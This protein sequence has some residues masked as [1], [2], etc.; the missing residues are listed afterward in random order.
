M[1][2]AGLVW[3]GGYGVQ[4]KVADGAMVERS[5]EQV[6]GMGMMGLGGIGGDHRRHAV[7][8]RRDRGRRATAARDGR[9]V[10]GDLAGA[11]TAAA[12]EP[13]AR[14]RALFVRMALAAA[15]LTFVVIVAS[16]FMRHAQAGL[17]CGDWPAC[18]ARVAAPLASA[19]P[20]AGVQFARIAHRLAATGVLALVIALMLVARTRR[21]AWRREGRL[22][23]VALLVVVAL[24][25]L[26]IATPGARLPAV[27][28][29]NLLGGY[30]LLAALAAT[31]AVAATAGAATAT[32]RGRAQ[33]PAVIALAAVLVQAAL[34]GLI[35]A[36]FASPACAA[37]VDCGAW[38]W[39]AFVD[40]G[41]WSPLRTP[42][43]VDGH[44]IA[45]AGAAGLHL[46]HRANGL[47][48]AALV[49][50]TVAAMWRGRARAAW[51][52]SA[53]LVAAAVSGIAAVS[54]APA[55]AVVVVHNACAALLVATLA[56]A[57]AAR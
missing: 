47:L 49:L 21:P 36:Q 56:W 3:S 41:A 4:R 12:A 25:G 26:G 18:Y 20:D 27:T 39:S 33:T 44:A 53:L 37:L 29:G 55:L 23:Q 15:A 28:L 34:G 40:G 13:A 35:G 42:A 10:A 2:I 31:A 24:A 45:P 19:P 7:R 57:A 6:A 50:V 46:L 51:M 17:S 5:L 30:A 38:S 43:V 1:H 14:L 11:M 32:A 48:V 8:R 22:A 9:G 16:A 52:L 54:P